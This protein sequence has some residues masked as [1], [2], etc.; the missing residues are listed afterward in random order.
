MNCF[1]FSEQFYSENMGKRV[2]LY[3]MKASRKSLQITLKFDE[4]DSS[5]ISVEGDSIRPTPNIAELLL[6]QHLADH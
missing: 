3:G 2:L 5:N 4:I 6:G 1:R